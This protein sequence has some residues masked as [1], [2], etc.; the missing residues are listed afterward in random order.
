MLDNLSQ[1]Q[2]EQA[3]K[4]LA[5]PIKNPPPQELEKINDLEWFLLNR[6][7]LTLMEEKLQSPL[8]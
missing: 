2:V 7:L 5:E 1:P 3:L 6:M 4:W 8:Q